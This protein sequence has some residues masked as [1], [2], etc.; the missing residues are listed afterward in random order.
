MKHVQ[1]K[2]NE[3]ALLDRLPMEFLPKQTPP[4]KDIANVYRLKMQ[5]ELVC[6]YHAV[7]GFPTKPTWVAAIKN[8]QFASW[9]GLTAKA[10]TK[11]FPDSK[12]TTK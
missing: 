5:P 2:N 12:E 11:H 6:Y 4:T 8:R 10:F 7:A 9:P 1:N 3:T